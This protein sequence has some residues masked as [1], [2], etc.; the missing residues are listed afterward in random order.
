M[1]LTHNYGILLGHLSELPAPMKDA[2][3]AALGL[4]YLC[5]YIL[6]AIFAPLQSRLGRTGLALIAGGIAGNFTDRL[7][8]GHVTDFIQW[9]SATWASPIFNVADICQWIGLPLLAWGL[10]RDARTFWPDHDFRQRWIVNW[11]FQWRASLVFAGTSAAGALTAAGFSF[12]FFSTAL[13]G[14]V[15]LPFLAAVGLLTLCLASSTFLLGLW[16]SHRVAGPI[17]ALQRHLREARAGKP[18]PLRL[19]KGDA[20]QDL[21]F[22]ELTKE[23]DDDA[24]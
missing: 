24:A 22:P 7:W 6:V 3:L 5:G 14:H 17:Y 11:P 12:A 15:R 8:H 1:H 9:K 19:R 13:E 18:G 10:C 23:N 4:A 2:T 21:E 16:L 20:F